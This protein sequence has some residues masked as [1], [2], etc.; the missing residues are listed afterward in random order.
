VQSKN[1]LNLFGSIWRS[2]AIQGI[3]ILKS[4]PSIILQNSL[5]DLILISLHLLHISNANGLNRLIIYIYQPFCS[6]L[7]SFSTNSQF[8]QT[9][10]STESLSLTFFRVS[11]SLN[12]FGRPSLKME[13]IQDFF[14]DFQGSYEC[15]QVDYWIESRPSLSFLGSKLIALFRYQKSFSLVLEYYIIS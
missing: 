2:W 8:N 6:E 11:S 15:T 9:Q 5:P 3:Y 1:V 13:I 12:A 4:V 14:R 10:I 7:S